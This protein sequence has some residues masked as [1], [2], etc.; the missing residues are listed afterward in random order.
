[1]TISGVLGATTSGPTGSVYDQV[2]DH[3]TG[4][5]FGNTC[6]TNFNF[7]V[8]DRSPSWI[9]ETN[10]KFIKF[11]EM[12]F[13]WLGC[14][15]D[16]AILE[17]MKDVDVTPD[18]FIKLFKEV[19]A[20][21]FPDQTIKTWRGDDHSV[22]VD[23]DDPDNTRSQILVDF[24]NPSESNVDVRNFLRYVKTLYQ[25][26][27]IEE[28]YEQVLAKASKLQE[29]YVD[30]TIKYK[31]WKEEVVEVN[32]VCKEKKLPFRMI[33]WK[34]GKN[35]LLNK[36]MAT[37]PDKLIEFDDNTIKE[38]IETIAWNNSFGNGG[39]Y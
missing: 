2:W 4:L 33:D 34:Y 31:D 25:M 39:I 7:F 18:A 27:S 16:S 5:D 3:I 23:T 30:G 9:M 19:F 14:N 10:P 1:M 32:K 26:K 22:F 11:I 36:L 15:N 28:A 24:L 37:M 21:G 38:R 8:K 6:E 17:Y 20:F 29:G 13:E 12:F 35:Q